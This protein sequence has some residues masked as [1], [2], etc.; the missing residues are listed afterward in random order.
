MRS[1]SS[2]EPIFPARGGIDGRTRCGRPWWKQQTSRRGARSSIRSSIWPTECPSR[3][4]ISPP[5]RKA[6]DSV[7]G[8]FA[9]LILAINKKNSLL[10]L[11]RVN[12]N[13]IQSLIVFCCICTLDIIHFGAPAWRTPR[14]RVRFWLPGIVVARL[15]ARALLKPRGVRLPAAGQ[16]VSARGRRGTPTSPTPPRSA[17]VGHPSR[18]RCSPARQV[19]RARPRRAA[20]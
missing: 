2:L 20:F 11:K 13:L 10:V 5:A 19:W 1:S 8:I 18:G 16:A 7:A 9:R 6:H 15:L 12:K 17:G 14:G 4:A 3:T